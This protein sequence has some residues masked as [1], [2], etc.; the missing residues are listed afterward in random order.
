MISN[1]AVTGHCGKQL[2]AAIV[3]ND[4]RCPVLKMTEDARPVFSVEQTS[5]PAFRRAI[6]KERISDGR[7]FGEPKPMGKMRLRSESVTNTRFQRIICTVAIKQRSYTDRTKDSRQNVLI[8]RMRAM[9]SNPFV[10]L[11]SER[12]VATFSQEDRLSK[13]LSQPRSSIIEVQSHN[14]H[15]VALCRVRFKR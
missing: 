9:N 14:D 13:F 4:E 6:R 8:L 2:D 10:P 3:T 5:T 15:W 7:E 12:S 1:D 11:L